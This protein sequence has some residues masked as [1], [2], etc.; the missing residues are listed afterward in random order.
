MHAPT[1]CYLALPLALPVVALIGAGLAGGCAPSSELDDSGQPIP[2][3]LSR[4]GPAMDTG[5]LAVERDDIDW[6][7]EELVDLPCGMSKQSVFVNQRTDAWVF[8]SMMGNSECASSSYFWHWRPADDGT[9]KVLDAHAFEH[10]TRHRLHQSLRRRIASARLAR[11]QNGRRVGCPHPLRARQE[12]SHN[13]H[14]QAGSALCERR[15]ASLPRVP[16]RVDA[17]LFVTGGR[18][19]LSLHMQRS[20]PG[21]VRAFLSV[22]RAPN[23][24]YEGTAPPAQLVVLE[25]FAVTDAR[26][27]TM[28]QWAC[29]AQVR[30]APILEW[31]EP[32]KPTATTRATR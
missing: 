17:S 10:R 4:V 16:P 9:Q 12:Q 28:A 11:L 20:P 14:E 7:A 5:E 27:A 18:A 19:E 26:P 13:R 6:D 29:A 25:L 21:A 23:M 30:V 3:P 32:Q 24:L 2:G 1:R 22:C 8:V 31:E 15:R